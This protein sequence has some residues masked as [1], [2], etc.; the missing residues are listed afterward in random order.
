MTPP[1]AKMG[2]APRLHA[3]DPDTYGLTL[4]NR[5]WVVQE[6]MG[7]RILADAAM[8]VDFIGLRGAR[9]V[10]CARCSRRAG[11]GGVSP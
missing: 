6:S 11:S 10:K 4:C 1:A 5:L 9:L 2:R 7:I 3:M 8:L